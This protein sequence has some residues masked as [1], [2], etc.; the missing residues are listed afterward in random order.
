MPRSS[1]PSFITEYELETTA[2]D[3]RKLGVSLDCGRQVYNAC[4]G[5]ALR[6]MRKLRVDEQYQA[7]KKMPNE[8]DSKP[9]K[10]RRDAFKMSRER[11]H[12]SE[13]DLHAYAKQF[14]HAWHW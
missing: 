4:L 11:S 12:F 8:V 3:R 7:A 5:E 9:N 14:S 13:Y 1:T 2:S 6:R 10:E